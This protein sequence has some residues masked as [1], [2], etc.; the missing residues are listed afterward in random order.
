MTTAP[1]HFHR[2]G[3]RWYT[4][5]GAEDTN[6][7]SDQCTF[8]YTEE[9]NIFPSGGYRFGSQARSQQ[10]VPALEQSLTASSMVPIS[11]QGTANTTSNLG[12]LLWTPLR[13]S[14]A[15]LLR[16]ADGPSPNIG[17]LIR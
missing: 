6:H 11:L 8:G 1:A 7:S 12:L 16:K 13:S 10:P 17:E 9:R 4:H 3:Y 5:H 2:E 14:H 15:S